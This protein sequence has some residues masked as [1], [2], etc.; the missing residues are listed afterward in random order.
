MELTQLEVLMLPSLSMPLFKQV[1]DVGS[2]VEI[3]LLRALSFT[4]Q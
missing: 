3:P 1:T 2:R 4:F